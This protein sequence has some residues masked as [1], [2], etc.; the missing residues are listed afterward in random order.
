[1]GLLYGQA[2][3]LARKIREHSITGRAITLGRQDVFIK[4]QDFGKFCVDA[5]VANMF[6]NEA[7]LIFDNSETQRRVAALTS[8]GLHTNRNF[9]GFISDTLLFT[10]LG[11]YTVD[12]IDINQH[13]D[14]THVFDMNDRNILESVRSTY[15]LVLDAG[16]MEHVFDVRNTFANITDLTNVGGFIAHI[17]PSNNTLD[18]GFYQFSPTLFQDYYYYNNYDVLDV[19]IMEYQRNPYHPPVNSIHDFL[20]AYDSYREWRYDQQIFNLTKKFGGPS[21]GG[22]SAGVFYTNALVRKRHDSLRDRPP[23][24]RLYFPY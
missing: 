13:A 24:Q 7:R 4:A 19:T 2:I 16:M 9:P 3:Y 11:I 12:A 10:A 20:S 17:M 15:D 21:F 6:D 14:V 23:L 18:H 5:G 8:G 1:M 22:L